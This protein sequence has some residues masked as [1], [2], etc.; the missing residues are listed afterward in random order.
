MAI[1][2]ISQSVITNATGLVRSSTDISA[3]TLDNLE[4]TL[5]VLCWVCAPC[6][7]GVAAG[8]GVLATSVRQQPKLSGDPCQYLRRVLLGDNGVVK[9]LCAPMVAAV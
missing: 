4:A 1:F 3:S 6:R 5:E 9:G 7:F 8:T 2:N